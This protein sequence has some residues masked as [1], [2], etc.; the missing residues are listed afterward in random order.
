[1]TLPEKLPKVRQFLQS[2]ID[3]GEGPRI[4]CLCGSS[5]WPEI[6]M[7]V[8]MNETL[9]GRI[10]VPMGLYGHANF[11]AGAREAT[12][13]GDEA[14]EVKQLLDR[15]H[16]AKIDLSDEIL[17]VNVGG[18]IGNSTKRE[19]EYA[20]TRGKG[21]R[22]LECDEESEIP[23]RPLS[24]TLSQLMAKGLLLALDILSHTA[25]SETCADEAFACNHPSDADDAI[26]GI[27]DLF[28]NDMLTS[29]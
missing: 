21:V 14:T 27:L 26:Q 11:P 6:H 18:Y 28:P 20:K 15:L 5:K 9:A 13:D 16:F 3:A 24:R 19:I 29:T 23:S 17:V 25:A 4:V 2:V 22:W 7:E 12:N 10:V 1:M 8:M